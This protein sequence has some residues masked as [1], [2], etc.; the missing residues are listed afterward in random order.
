MKRLFASIFCSLAVVLAVIVAAGCDRGA[1]TQDTTPPPSYAE[2]EKT[3][4][5]ALFIVGDYFQPEFI[6]ELMVIAQGITA[7]GGR[8]TFICSDEFHAPLSR[9]LEANGVNGSGFLSY[10]AGD[11]VLREWARDVAVVGLGSD[12]T[13]VVVSPN[14]HAASR[15]A[16]R[17]LEGIVREVMGPGTRV[18]VAPFVFEGGN[19]AFVDAG[20]RGTVLLV[21]RKMVFDNE[22][23]QRRAWAGALEGSGL[24]DEVRSTF[25]VDSVVVVGRA[26]ERPP[27][28]MYFE[29]H[30]DMGMAILEERRAVVS[31]LRVEEA[32]VAALALAVAEGRNVVAP[33]NREDRPDDELVAALAARLATVAAEYDDYAA[34]LEGLGLD[35]YRSRVTWR[36]VLSSMSWTNVLQAGNTIFMPV[37]PES[38]CARAT[39]AET[40]GGR[41]YLTLEDSLLGD[42]RFALDGSNGENFELYRS[43]GYRVVPVPEYLHYFKGGIH[44]F[45]NVT[46]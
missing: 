43:L 8:S 36:D 21:G 2:H 44:C 20:E 35:V 30:L 40:S 29:Y 13:A 1:R 18:V 22:V 9:L 41:F 5:T 19:L 28:A 26:A 23:Y 16:A 42:E 15:A 6:A 31:Q 24:L 3:G 32:D 25:R 7:E 4:G 38:L 37:Y 11:E 33:F 27:T 45:V 34:L 12:S 17:A 39:E 14:K 46:E 10:D